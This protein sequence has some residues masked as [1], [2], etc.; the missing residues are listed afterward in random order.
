MANR[1]RRLM[2]AMVSIAAAALGAPASAGAFRVNPVQIKLPADQKAASLTIAN[3]DA[4]PVAIK[5]VAL[6]WSQQNGEDTYRPTDDVIISPPIFS[7]AAGGTQLVRVGLKTRGGGA[8]YRI[9]LEEIPRQKAI[10]G[11]VQVVLRLNLPLYVLPAG[12]G[13]PDVSWRAWRSAD[14]TIDVEATNRG[15]LH[16]QIAEL[17]AALGG[18]K[19]EVLS[20]EMGVV[21]PASSRIWK[22]RGE[23]L[24]GSGA[25]FT[26]KVRSSTGEI[27]APLVLESR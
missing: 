8:A 7:I 1:S 13:K 4:A 16:L 27:D 12:G 26:L 25:S 22:V 23:T 9:F 14:G 18:G 24:L 15:S 17:S 19:T 6:A 3:S 11:Q 2:I 5:A 20:K 10:D 21:L